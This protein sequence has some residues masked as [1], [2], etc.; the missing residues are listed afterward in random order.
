MAIQA[1]HPTLTE[2]EASDESV[3]AIAYVSSFHAKWFWNGVAT[4]SQSQTSR[5]NILAG[6][7]GASAQLAR[8]RKCLT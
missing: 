6:I 3:K 4:G 1:H 7:D 8:E 2:K 5:R